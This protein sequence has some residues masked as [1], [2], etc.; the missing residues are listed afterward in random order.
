MAK[1]KLCKVVLTIILATSNT[2][3]ASETFRNFYA[4]VFKYGNKSLK[5]IHHVGDLMEANPNFLGMVKKCHKSCFN[6]QKHI[7]Q[8]SDKEIALITT[9]LVAATAL[10]IYINYKIIRKTS[11]IIA[12]CDGSCQKSQDCKDQAIAD[13]RQS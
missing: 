8:A 7:T 11:A 3:Q 5:A 6:M 4:N 9:G 2:G 13:R 12:G 10:G 1:N